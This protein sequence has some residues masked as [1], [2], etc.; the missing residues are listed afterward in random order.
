MTSAALKKISKKIDDEIRLSFY[1]AM[2]LFETN[3]I[4]AIGEM[5]NR[6]RRKKH[7]KKTFYSANFH[8]NPT[9]ICVTQCG[10]CAFSRKKNDVGAYVLSI[11]EIKKT[12]A[13]AIRKS[14]I[15]EVH[16]VGGHNPDL[17]FDYY[18]EML[19]S[20]K[21]LGRDKN[22]FIK[23][24]SAP[25][26][27][28]MANRAEISISQTLTELKEA[29]LDSMPGGGAEIFD[30]AV[31]EKI[32]PKK[33]SASRWLNIHRTAHKLGIGTNATILYGHIET[34]E[35]RARHL[36]ELRDLQDETKGFLAF[37]P[38]AFNPERNAIKE[39][40]ET[41]GFLDLKMLSISRLI[42][43]NIAHIKAHGAATNFKFLSVAISFGADDVGGINLNEKVMKEA[44][45][46]SGAILDQNGI[47]R[48][49]ED[50]GFEPLLVTSDY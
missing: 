30:E 46:Q 39:V 15:N 6:V 29:G 43:D 14:S 3:D 22:V 19:R 26:I 37:V 50:A 41:S 12:V 11:E 28:F 34:N 16:I 36:L 24:F 48:F 38:L 32:C 40:F 13:K 45:S 35:H 18:L 7:G 4:L 9:N 33:I 23:A 49:I 47:R 31:R 21:K 1:D 2:T 44:G 42:L 20:I 27:D 5:A 8:L 10:F 17:T 25:E